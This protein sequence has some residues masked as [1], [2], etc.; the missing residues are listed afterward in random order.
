MDYR[1]HWNGIEMS[2]ND[3]FVHED[4]RRLFI[5]WIENTEV[6]SLKALIMKSNKIVGRHYHKKKEEYFFLLSGTANKVVIGPQEY[7]N[8]IAPFKWVVPKN[9]YHSFDLAIDS[10]LLAATTKPFDPGD[11]YV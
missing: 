7:T 11:D 2:N 1:K 9:T 8:I 10:I 6:C 3:F 5:E 4:E